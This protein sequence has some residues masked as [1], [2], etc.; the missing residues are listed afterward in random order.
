M[1]KVLVIAITIVGLATVP[2]GRS[3]AAAKRYKNC[4]ALNRDYPNGISRKA[5]PALYEANKHLDRDKDG[6]ACEK[7]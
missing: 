2:A 3:E 1:K 7:K 5:Q 6:R 4:K